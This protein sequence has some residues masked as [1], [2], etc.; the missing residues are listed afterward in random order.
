MLRVFS[1]AGL[2]I[3]S[4]AHSGDVVAKRQAGE[5]ASELT[6][7]EHRLVRAWIDGIER[8]SALC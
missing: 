6:Q 1:L 5:V 3:V 4:L 7:I 8:P 2:P